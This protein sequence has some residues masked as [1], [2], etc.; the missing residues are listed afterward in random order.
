MDTNDILRIVLV[1]VFAAC[2]F[3]PGFRVKVSGPVQIT[4]AEETEN[5]KTQQQLQSS[6]DAVDK[7]VSNV[8]AY[9]RASSAIV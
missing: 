2:A 9:N 7:E 5:I 6:E 8:P 4:E 3:L 1:A